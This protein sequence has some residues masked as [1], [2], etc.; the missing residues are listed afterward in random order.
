M[1]LD[2]LRHLRQT[3][4]QRHD[5][6]IA[7]IDVIIAEAVSEWKS[8]KTAPRDGTRFLATVRVFSART[9]EF[10][11][12]DTHLV[13]IDTRTDEIDISADQGWSLEDY[14]YWMPLPEPPTDAAS[15]TTT[16]PSDK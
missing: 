3:L 16:P 15:H 10:S 6:A 2:A 8:I 1:T 7:A 11:H 5:E 14:E 4:V 13:W 9:G 12:H